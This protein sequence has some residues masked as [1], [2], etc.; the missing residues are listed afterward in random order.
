MALKKNN[1]THNPVNKWAR[2]LS[3]LSEEV[4]R[5]NPYI[6][7]AQHSSCQ[8]N[9]Y[10]NF[11]KIPSYPISNGYHEEDKERWAKPP[12]HLA[13]GNV[14]QRSYSANQ[15]GKSHQE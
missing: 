8:E 6:Q 4:Q 11:T 5:P 1:S 2:E 12:S 9:A 13:A 3:K 7:N 10:L 14:N 15:C